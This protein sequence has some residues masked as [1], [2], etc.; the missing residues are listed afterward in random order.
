MQPIDASRLDFSRSN[1]L[2]CDIYRYKGRL[3]F[4]IFIG[5]LCDVEELFVY[6]RLDGPDPVIQ[7]WLSLAAEFNAPHTIHGCADMFPQ[8]I[9]GMLME[10]LMRTWRSWNITNLSEDKHGQGLSRFVEASSIITRSLGRYVKVSCSILK[11]YAHCYF[12]KTQ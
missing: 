10:S 6:H 2:N 9:A 3:P 7:F 4:Q 8:S 12:L 11:V 5:F 1:V